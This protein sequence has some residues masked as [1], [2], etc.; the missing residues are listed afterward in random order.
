MVVI[1]SFGAI[2]G[3]ALAIFLILKKLHPVY[4]LLAGALVGGVVGGASMQDTVNFMFAG[5]KDILPAVLRVLAAG[6]LAGVLMESGASITI[7]ETIIKTVG[8]KRILW[9]LALSTFI[10]TASGVFIYVAVITVAPIALTLGLRTHTS[11]AA[12]LLAMIGGGKAG[13]IISPNPNTIAAADAFKLELTTVMLAGI[14]PALVGIVASAL[15]AG[16]L[17]KKGEMVGEEHINYQHQ[18][19]PSFLAAISG[20]VLAIALLALNPLTGIK[21]DPMIALPVGGI[22]G[23]LFMGK[24]KNISQYASSGLDKT[25]GVA[26]LLLCTG[27]IAGIIANS[28]LKDIITNGLQSFGL[29]AFLLAPLSGIAMSAATASTTSGTAVA[30]TVFGPTILSLGVPAL[31]AAAMVHAGA[32]VLDHLPHGSFFHA[33]SGSVFMDIRQRLQ[34]I[35]YETLIGLVLTIVSTLIFGF[36]AN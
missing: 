6:V 9:A 31:S 28:T 7:A 22:A 20:P 12:I 4:A 30:S 17:N 2:I 32:T 10:L 8:E 33:S 15:V 14:V 34:L 29:P 18:N 3:L 23:A 5:S 24:I 35:P 25:L 13:N 19:L 1:S 36:F 21:I 27:C 16:V 11:K 26:V